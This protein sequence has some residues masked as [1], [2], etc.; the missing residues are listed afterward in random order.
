MIG[1]VRQG[2]HVGARHGGFDRVRV[3]V[4]D[5]DRDDPAHLAPRLHLVAA[6]AKG[7]PA[8]C[9]PLDR[10]PAQGRTLCKELRLDVVF[11]EQSGPLSLFG[12]E[13]EQV[14][15]FNVDDRLRVT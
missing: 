4:G 2:H 3:L 8:Q 1:T 15:A 10:V 6:R 7:V 9:D 14:V 13:R 5:R 12:E 11:N